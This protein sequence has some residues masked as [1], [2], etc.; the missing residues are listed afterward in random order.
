MVNISW[1]VECVEKRER[2]DES[3]F[4][5]DLEAI[6]VA[7]ANKVGISLHI[8]FYNF[9][10]QLTSC[11]QRRKS[12]LPKQLPVLGPMDMFMD[13]KASASSKDKTSVRPSF[14]QQSRKFVFLKCKKKVLTSV[15]RPL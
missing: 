5:V 9:Y 4:T 7:G 6:N 15:R 11:A 13:N 12:V 2:I 1:V 10:N 14:S 3:R 8:L